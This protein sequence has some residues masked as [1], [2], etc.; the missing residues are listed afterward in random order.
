MQVRRFAALGGMIVSLLDC[1]V[2]HL[3]AA[4]GIPAMKCWTTAIP[5]LSR[6]SVLV[7]G[8]F[9]AATLVA[10]DRHPIPAEHPRVFG[11][12][13]ELQALANQ[14]A[15]EYHRMLAVARRSGADDHAAMVSQSLV[16]AIEHD[17]DL[18]RQ[19]KQ[20]ALK[21]V[22]GPIRVGHVTFGHDLALCA[23]AYDLAFEWWTAEERERFHSY[24]NR[25]VDANVQSETHVFHNAVWLQELGHWFGCLRQLPREPALPRDPQGAGTGLP[26][27][28]RPRPRVGRRWWRLG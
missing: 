8:G 5:S 27:S 4:P 24:F 28:G 11:S 12:R 10:E 18:G 22:D 26:D 16:A 15:E 2:R 13:A 3:D 19:A 7:S 9:L 17:A 20:R 21:F 6:L 25:T 23:L 1:G 14:R